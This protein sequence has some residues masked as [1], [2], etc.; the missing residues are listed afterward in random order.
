MA[1][2]RILVLV[3]AGGAGGRLELLTEQRA[4]PAVP[5]AGVYRLIDFPLS[6]LPALGHRRRLGVRAVPPDVAVGA[7]G[8]RPALGPGPHH[9]RPDDPAAVPRHRPRRL[10]HRH[11]GLAVAA[12]RPGPRRSP[13]TRSSS[14]APTPSTSWTTA[15]SSRQHLRL[16]RRGH[17]GDH[18]GRRRRRLALRH[19]ARSATATGSPTTPTSPTSRRR[20]R[21][22]T[23]S[24]SSPRR[25]RWTGWRRW[26]PT[27]ARTGWTT[28]ATALLPAQ[29]ARRPGPRAPAAR[30]TGATSARCRP[31]GRRT[32]DFLAARAADRPGRPGLAA[33]H[34][35]RPAQRGPAAARRRGRGQPG[36]RRHPGGR[37]GARLGAVPGRRGRAG[38]DRH[39]LGAAARRAGAGRARR[40]TA[41]CSTTG[42]TSARTPRSAGTA[43][44]RGSPWSGGRRGWDPARWSGPAGASPRSSRTDGP[45]RRDHAPT[46]VRTG[47]RDHRGGH[48][49][50]F[51]GLVKTY[52][53]NRV[54]QG[55]GF[56]VAPGQMYGFCGANGAGKTTTMR[57]AMGLA[58]A[59]AGQVRWRG[60]PLDEA[61]RPRIGYMPEERGLYPKMKV[62]RAARPT[63]PGCTGSPRPTPR[64]RRSTGPSASG[65]ASAAT[66]GWR[67]CRWATSSG[68][69]SPRPWSA[70]PRC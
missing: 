31:T 60:R 35:R 38:R 19:R 27:P 28:S 39:R 22:P 8:Q 64:P 63:S 16:R 11:R 62:V 33:A 24:S 66:T 7:P 18:R 59:D 26:P 29:T 53:G 55:V 14:S 4:K 2:P 32:C 58:R 42:S 51:D 5:F 34:P 30:A 13:R 6:Q 3:L 37:G 70:G 9:R 67:S 1:L 45:R 57:I 10:G 52:G 49:L 68:S 47:T 12:G 20:R 65:S 56:T 43:R 17:D 41:R 61:I 44:R 54:L 15:R 48:V 69:S 40:C 50:E 36:L 25:R 46:T 23:R 21:P